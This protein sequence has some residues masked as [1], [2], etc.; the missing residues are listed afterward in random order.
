M[1]RVA[2]LLVLALSLA[3]CDMVSTL[4][5]GYKY[6]KAV[7]ADLE[8]SIGMRPQVGF[9]WSNGRLVTVSVTFP[10]ID[11]KDH[12][13]NSPRPCAMPSPVISGKRPKIS[14]SA[15]HCE[16]PVR[17]R[18]R[19]WASRI[20]GKT[21]RSRDACAPEVCQARRK[22]FTSRGKSRGER[23][24]E[25]RIQPMSAQRRQALPLAC[26]R[27]RKRAESRGALAFR[28]SAAAGRYF[29]AQTVLC[30]THPSIHAMTARADCL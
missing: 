4:V 15:S 13:P 6:T 27:A 14:C 26:A 7:E 8:A 12:C 18:W 23:S 11:E 9:N 25:R 2:A 21:H 10:R 29:S 30:P 24:A 28:R 17:A 22:S 5:D 20:S 16:S 1:L 19:N 3:G